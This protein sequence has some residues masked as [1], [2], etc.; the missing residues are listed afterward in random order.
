[1][2]IDYNMEVILDSNFVVSCIK[3]RIDYLE[4]LTNLGF[5]V[6]VPREVIDELKDL[7]MR[8][9]HAERV[10]IDVALEQFTKHKVKKMKLGGTNIDEGLI[11]KG[12]EGIHIATLDVAI[13]RA[14]PNRVII[15]NAQNSLMI[16]RQ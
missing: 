12:K 9:N 2:F 16:E 3:K 14:I 5:K 4:E 10:A 15:S 8:V 13:K 1:M 11:A 6:V 7:R